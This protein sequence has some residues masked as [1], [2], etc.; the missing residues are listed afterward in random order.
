MEYEPACRVKMSTPTAI[1]TKCLAKNVTKSNDSIQIMSTRD[2]THGG[3][4][5]PAQW[6]S[7]CDYFRLSTRNVAL[8]FTS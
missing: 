1:D 8:D 7:L 4:F 6:R 2:S 3:S 5:V